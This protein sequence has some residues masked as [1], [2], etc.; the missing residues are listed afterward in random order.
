MSDK[1]IVYA[2]DRKYAESHEWAKP[3]GDLVVIGISDYAQDQLGDVVFVELP[4][5]G[6]TVSA[7][8]T[9]G[10]VESVKAASDVYAPISGA[11][12]EINESL[13]EHPE[14]VNKDAFNAGWFIKVRPSNAG[15]M[16]KLFDAA[17]YQGKI[18]AGEIH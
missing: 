12:A 18:E 7:G 3:E 10:V 2:T 6:A 8:K 16:E 15:E 1:K 11:V 5:V 9:F 13:K 14:T 17:T 4:S